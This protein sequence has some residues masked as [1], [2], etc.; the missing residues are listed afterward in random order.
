VQVRCKQKV[1]VSFNSIEIS[2]C[3]VP[4]NIEIKG[5]CSDSCKDNVTLDVYKKNEDGSYILYCTLTSILDQFD[6]TGKAS[7]SL[8]KGEYLVTPKKQVVDICVVVFQRWVVFVHPANVVVKM[9]YSQ[10]PV[11]AKKLIYHF[12]VTNCVG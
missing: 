6:K 4:V 10:L 3:Q 12:C 11:I 1:Y 5:R 9:L 7:A 2:D 8:P